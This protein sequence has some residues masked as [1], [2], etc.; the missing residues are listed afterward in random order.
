MTL[1][2]RALVRLVCVATVATAGL[3][4][5]AAA[6][7]AHSDLVESNPGDGELVL[8]IPPEVVLTFSGGVQPEYTEV[9]VLY[10]GVSVDVADPVTD[11]NEVRQPLEP[12]PADVTSADVTISFRIVSAD[13]HPVDGTLTFVA[14]AT[15]TVEQTEDPGPSPDDDSTPAA[16]D[17]SDDGSTSDTSTGT[18]V[19]IGAAVAVVIVVAGF[20]VRRR[21]RRGR[22]EEGPNS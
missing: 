20:E 2:L 5:G 3:T 9:G 21:A 13:G 18:L 22:P 14:D 7:S 8:E 10:D 1:R 16:A 15:A 11:G 17:T 12:L 4:L 19:A 6:A